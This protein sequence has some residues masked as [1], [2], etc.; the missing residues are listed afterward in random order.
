MAARII[1]QPLGE[2]LGQPIV[3]ENKP[4]VAGNLGTGL[5]TKEPADG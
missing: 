3:V 4:G 2:R 1:A 5:F